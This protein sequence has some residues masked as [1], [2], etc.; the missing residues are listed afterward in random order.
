MR[1]WCFFWRMKGKSIGI[2]YCSICNN[3]LTT[4]SSLRGLTQ[5]T[6]PCSAPTHLCAQTQVSFPFWIQIIQDKRK[7]TISCGAFS[8]RQQEMWWYSERWDNRR[9]VERPTTGFLSVL[10]SKTAPP[11]VKWIALLSLSLCVCMC[12]F[13]SP[14]IHLLFFINTSHSR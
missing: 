2:A 11:A 14:P 3:S 4:T 5:T 1:V 10:S 8:I 13:K 9:N 7:R 12:V 6:N